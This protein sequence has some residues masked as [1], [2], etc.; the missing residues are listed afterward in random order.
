MEALRIVLSVAS[1]FSEHSLWPIHKGCSSCVDWTKALL[2]LTLFKMNET[3]KKIELERR[4]SLSEWVPFFVS[5]VCH[6][7]TEPCW[8]KLFSRPLLASRKRPVDGASI[9]RRLSLWL[10]RFSCIFSMDKKKLWFP[11]LFQTEKWNVR[12]QSVRVHLQHFQSPRSYRM[13]ALSSVAKSLLI[14]W[15]ANAEANCNKL[16]L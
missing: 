16:S 4:E 1:A 3:G 13:R 9:V 8:T 14:Q 10:T 5:E 15:V 12:P 6:F 7:S 11:W 2:S